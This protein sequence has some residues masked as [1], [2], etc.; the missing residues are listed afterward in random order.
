MLQRIIAF[1]STRFKDIALRRLTGNILALG[2]LQLV[3]IV[4]PFLTVPYLV[5][6]IGVDLYGLYAFSTAIIAYFL[7]LIDYGF[8]LSATRQISVHRKSREELVKIFSAVLT[9]KVVFFIFGFLLLLVLMMFSSMIS[10]YWSLYLLMYLSLLGQVVTPF[11]LFQGLEKIYVGT[12][13]TLF[14]RGIFVLGIFYFVVS[15]SDFLLIPLISGFGFLLSGLV[16]L[17]FV[18]VEY[19]FRFALQSFKVLKEQLK[20][21]F[22]LFISNVSISLYTLSSTLILGIFSSNLI[23]GYYAGADKIIQVLR[24]LLSSFSQ[25][26]FPYW[27][28]KLHEDF[29]VGFKYVVS[30]VYYIGAFTF[31]L[32][33]TV[34]LMSDNLVAIALGPE[35]E[36]SA[37]L[38]RILSFT[39][40]F[41]SLSNIFGVQLMLNMGLRREFAIIVTITAFLGVVMSLSL[42][43]KFQAVGISWAVLFSEMFIAVLS[44]LAVWHKRKSIDDLSKVKGTV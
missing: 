29:D 27:S 25:A 15:K 2:L 23:V 1:V 7:L 40:F 8:N 30:S 14:S 24:A 20:E 22:S 35:F 43:V 19:G 10:D 34:Y 33:C 37:E 13:L 32:S 5:R 3:N 28:K 26:I 9:L 4:I 31:I 17:I 16:S 18:R 21:G 44:F 11:W 39:P 41:I 6:V 42:V 36:E 38:V 12:Y